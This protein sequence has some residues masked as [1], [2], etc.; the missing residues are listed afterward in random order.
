M[1]RSPSESHE[2][3]WAG[4]QQR[5]SRHAEQT[6]RRIRRKQQERERE[7]ERLLALGAD[8]VWVALVL[9]ESGDRAA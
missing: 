4:A 8:P 1:T 7:R 5:S 2:A 3:W 9:G 6:R